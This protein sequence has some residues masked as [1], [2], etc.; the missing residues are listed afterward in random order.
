MVLR[1]SNPVSARS[2][3]FSEENSENFQILAESEEF[4]IFPRKFRKDHGFLRNPK[5]FNFFPKILRKEC[6]FSSETVLIDVSEQD[7]TSR[8]CRSGHPSRPSHPSSS[9]QQLASGLPQMRT[10]LDSICTKHM[11]AS[12]TI[13]SKHAAGVDLTCSPSP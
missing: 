3:D 4:K 9:P 12:R 6:L 11:C 1:P 7:V 13:A 10:T 5:D 8:P 2:G